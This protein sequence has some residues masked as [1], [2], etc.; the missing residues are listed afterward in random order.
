MLGWENST[1][2]PT[3]VF[4][5]LNFFCFLFSARLLVFKLPLFFCSTPPPPTHTHRHPTEEATDLTSFPIS[6]RDL[7][8]LHSNVFEVF[9]G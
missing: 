8:L 2:S 3:P 1:V 6:K 9:P 7:F 4:I 5:L